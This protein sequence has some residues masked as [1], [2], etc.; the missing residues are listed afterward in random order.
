MATI[1]TG[2]RASQLAAELRDR[3]SRQPRWKALIGWQSYYRNFLE[4]IPGRARVDHRGPYLAD[5]ARQ[6]TLIEA[7]AAGKR[8]I[9]VTAP[10]GCG[11]SRLALEL[12]RQAGRAQRSW[13][14]RFVRHD[15]PALAEELVRLPQAQRLIL[16]VD[17]AHDCP[18]LVQQ[19]V[20]AAAAAQKPSQVHLLCLGRPAGRAAL[21]EV[22][23]SH[24]TADEILEL[25]LGRP[26]A[27]LIRDLIDKL[28]PQ[29]S[30]HHRDVIRRFAADSY[31]SPVLLC[32]SAARQQRLPQ[33]LST[34]NLRDYAVRQPVIQAVGDLC[35]LDKA[36]RALA[37]YAACAPVRCGDAALRSCA[38][39]HAALSISEIESLE[40]RVL[41][42][43]IFETDQRG[44]MRPVPDLVG[45]LI[46]EETC[47][48]EQGGPSPFG[49][50]LMRALFEQ[51]QYEPVIRNCGDIAR[52]FAAPAR[53]EFMTELVLERANGLPPQNRAQLLELL[54]GCA[55]LALRQPGAIAPLVD[56]LTTKGVLRA[57]PPGRE[58][59]HADN[60]EIR[61]QRLLVLAAEHDP[62]VVARALEYSR[63]LL[64][65]AGTDIGAC[66]ALRDNLLGFCQFAVARPLAHATAVL[67]VLEGWVASSDTGAAEL[68]ASL[69]HGFLTLQMRAR[70]WDGEASGFVPA[71]LTPAG[72]ILQLRDRALAI[73]VRCADHASAA[74]EYA[75]ADSLRHWA[76]GHQAMAAELR[77]RWAPELNR[78]LDTLAAR[79]GRLGIA[80]PHPPVIAAVEQ[81]GW[82][83]WLDGGEPYIQRCGRRILG[84]L[85]QAE[86][87]SLWKALH[88]PLLPALAVPLEDSI[89]PQDCRARGLALV[90]PSA[91]RAADL[92]RELLDRLDVRYKDA[93]AWSE[94]LTA[95]LSAQPL[96]PL[97]PL[98]PVYLEELVRR[99]PEKAWS[100]VSEEAAQAPLGAVLPA[101]LTA[102]RRQDP[103]RWQEAMQRSPPGTRLFRIEL[104]V[105]CVGG[106]LDA[107]ERRRV[108]E[109]L[110]LEDP[111]SVHLSAQ[112]LLRAAPDSLAPGMTAVSAT[113]AARPG[114]TRLWELTLAAFVRWGE[115]LL[116]APAEAGEPEPQLRAAAGE[117]LRLLR[118]C[119]GAL[120]WD[121]GPHARQLPAAMTLFAVVVPHTLKSWMR[122]E[123]STPGDAAA[124]ESA[125]SQARMAEILARVAKTSAAPFWRKQFAQW[126]TDEPDLAV[127]GAR[128]LAQLSDLADPCIAPL[129]SRIV[130]QQTDTS[131]EALRA[132][133]GSCGNSSRFMA[134]A[135][136]LL[137]RCSD[138]AEVYGPLE[139]EIIA[140]LSRA[141]SP[142]AAATAER[143]AAL[144][145]I[146]QAA[147]EADLPQPLR[148]TLARARQAVQGAI[149]EGL[150]RTEARCIALDGGL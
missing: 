105:L 135:L 74:V 104:A 15:E 1:R 144:R 138:V 17:D 141:E 95:A 134:D 142:D 113:L 11:K 2:T 145:A 39:T 89:Q 49:R 127:I 8:A 117:L 97:Q 41:A 101:L 47:L 149:E 28:I 131:R 81:L 103:Q 32:S 68:A 129:V 69:L 25:D 150:L 99:H 10:R 14:V 7:I 24:F 57:A 72:D 33:T 56:A 58:L 108:S 91:E 115:S 83:W 34:K 54:D 45:D 106:E 55:A 12:A 96:Q 102:L 133:I 38:A 125:L 20:A 84:S 64:A 50:S 122:Q 70:R 109:G 120:A 31:F 46:L 100:L 19:L 35:P 110:Q 60:P 132:L 136:T 128:S 67:D 112:A 78:E 98:A 44:L 86:G 140:T 23:A 88:A 124:S 118:A 16:I 111:Q 139:Q 107:V 66:R 13:D 21:T 73:L 116:S 4:E 114:D 130:Q 87:Y 26:T 121:Q 146:D 53:V 48:D 71:P 30:P 22:L 94:A 63:Q 65:C 147:Q 6:T 9:L 36:F 148:E 52:L 43:G 143:N 137:R 42:A 75:A 90:A 40:A 59:S 92:A 62:T 51:S 3:F 85:P 123:W 76:R 93:A 27:K 61:A 119:S 18:A 77:A 79:F 29:L 80:T 5:E 82:H 126:M 37:V